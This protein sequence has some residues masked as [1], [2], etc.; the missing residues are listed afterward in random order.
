MPGRATSLI[1][2]HYHTD[3]IDCPGIEPIPVSMRHNDEVCRSYS[4]RQACAFRG[5]R[6]IEGEIICPGCFKGTPA[7]RII[8]RQLA[9]GGFIVSAVGRSIDASGDNCSGPPDFT[10]NSK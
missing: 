7:E 2:S 9:S 4:G 10:P 6:A 3:F 8:R 5:L 1:E